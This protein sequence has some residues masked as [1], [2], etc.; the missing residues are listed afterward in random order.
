MAD[1]LIQ[2][3]HARTPRDVQ[4]AEG[5][6]ARSVRPSLH[7]IHRVVSD[8]TI[9]DGG[10]RQAILA[11][12]PSAHTVFLSRAAAIRGQL[13]EHA[14]RGRPL[15]KLLVELAFEGEAQAPLLTGR[16]ALRA[17]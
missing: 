9:P 10:L 17:L 7:A 3:L 4:E 16:S 14:R 12:M 6:G 1:R 5:R 2:D 8:P 11:L 15:G 13:S